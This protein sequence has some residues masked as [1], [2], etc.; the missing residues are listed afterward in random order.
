MLIAELL[1][2]SL[3]SRVPLWVW[4]GFGIIVIVAVVLALRRG[5]K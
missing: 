2:V 3:R 4:V 5:G 1:A